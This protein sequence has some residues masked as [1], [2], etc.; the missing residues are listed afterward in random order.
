MIT[1]KGFHFDLG[2]KCFNKQP[3]FMTQIVTWSTMLYS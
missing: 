2:H 3:A 1:L